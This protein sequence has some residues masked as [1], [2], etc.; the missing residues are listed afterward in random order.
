M[1][2]IPALSLLLLELLIRCFR[3]RKKYNEFNKELKQSGA[4]KMYAELQED[5]TMRSLIGKF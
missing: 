4:R 1:Y 5:P 3:L 2:L